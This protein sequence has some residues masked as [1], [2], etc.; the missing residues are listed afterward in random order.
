MSRHLTS[1]QISER[2]LGEGSQE[3]ELHLRDCSLCQEELS[4]FEDALKGFRTSVRHWSES[5]LPA[6][7]PSQARRNPVWSWMMGLCW[8]A[9]AIILCIVIGHLNYHPV[10]QAQTTAADAALLAQIDN[11]VSR[12]VPGPMEPLTQLVSWDANLSVPASDKAISESQT[13]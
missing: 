12:T 4:R 8:A 1:Q 10:P 6:P 2:V 9:A 7:V 13:Q 5:Q 11:E 3:M